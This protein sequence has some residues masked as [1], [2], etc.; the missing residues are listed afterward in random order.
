MTQTQSRFQ[1]GDHISVRRFHLYWHHG[2]YVN[3]DRVIEF[4]G[5]NVAEKFRA[6][7][8]PV[9]LHQFESAGKAEVTPP[10]WSMA[11]SVDDVIARADYVCS[12]PTR[13]MYNL[14]G[15]NCEHLARWCVE[16]DFWSYQV[17]SFALPLASLASLAFLRPR[18]RRWVTVEWTVAPVVLVNA[19]VRRV[20]AA[21]WKRL[22]AG[23][24]VPSHPPIRRLP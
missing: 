15:S 4:G 22:L 9:P 14:L 6:I 24:P 2:I 23:C 18:S 11:S 13:G 1:P 19:V 17:A 3:E 20:A 10:R 8:R 16:S 21:R 12:L 5:G 7:V